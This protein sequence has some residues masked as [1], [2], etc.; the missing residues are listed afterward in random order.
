VWLAQKYW[1]KEVDIVA[2]NSQ[3]YY[4]NK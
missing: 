1:E 2:R 4:R 3:M